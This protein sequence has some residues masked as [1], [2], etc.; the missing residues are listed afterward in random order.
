MPYTDEILD[1]F[2]VAEPP[3]LVREPESDSLRRGSRSLDVLDLARLKLLYDDS[4]DKP[5]GSYTVAAQ[6]A[7]LDVRISVGAVKRQGKPLEVAKSRTRQDAVEAQRGPSVDGVSHVL[8]VA[9]M[10]K[11]DCFD[12]LRP[13]GGER[14]SKPGDVV[15]VSC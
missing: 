13:D 7:V 2:T 14:R 11:G 3:A 4:R 6:S 1:D 8:L 5:V 12:V 10:G 15:I 9:D